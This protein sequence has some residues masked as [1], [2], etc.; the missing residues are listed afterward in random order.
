M[1]Q[2]AFSVADGIV[3]ADET[4]NED[5]RF[6]RGLAALRMSGEVC[7]STTSVEDDE[8]LELSHSTLAALNEFLAEKKEREDKLRQ[9]AEAAAD[10]EKLLDEVDLDE[11]WVRYTLIQC[12]LHDFLYKRLSCNTATKPILV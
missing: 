6:Q 2:Q 4:T 11:D 1:S 3:A 9:I 8:E 12:I 10:A 7:Q 5:I